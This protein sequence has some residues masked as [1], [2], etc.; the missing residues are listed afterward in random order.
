[1]TTAQL[2]RTIAQLPA[3]VKGQL[4]IRLAR[5]LTNAWPGIERTPGVHGG[6]ACIIR[7]R[8][9]VWTIETYRRL[10]WDD[11]ALLANFPTLR[12]ADL[13]YAA[14]YTQANRTEIDD[15]IRAQDAA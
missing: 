11:T 8:I 4:L 5:D 7:T 9:P 6:D 2:E 15:A 3:D 12:P 10:G 14:L 1:M 13:V